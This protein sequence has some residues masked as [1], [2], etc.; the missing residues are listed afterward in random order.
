MKNDVSTYPAGT[1]CINQ[2]G[3]GV[4]Y[5]LLDA[6]IESHDDMAIYCEWTSYRI[7]TLNSSAARF[8]GV[9]KNEA[10]G[11]GFFDLMPA[12]FAMGDYEE[13]ASLKADRKQ[14]VELLLNTSNDKAFNIKAA[15][16]NDGV[17]F[18]IKNVNKISESSEET[19]FKMLFENM[20]SG[21]VFLKGITDDKGNITN[22]QILDINS[23]FEIYFDKDKEQAIGKNIDD[24]IPDIDESVM[25]I[26]AK[27]ALTGNSYSGKYYH[28][29]TKK[30]FEVRTYSPRKGFS[31]AVFNDI[32]H[33]IEVRNDL[34]IKN[35]ISKAFALGHDAS[36]YKVVLDFVLKNTGS[37]GGFIGYVHQGR[38]VICLAH[39][40]KGYLP[41]PDA[42]GDLILEIKNN[43]LEV[44]FDSKEQLLETNTFDCNEILTTPVMDKDKV[45]G[46]ISCTDP[47]TT[48]TPKA[49]N[50][51]Q[52]LADYIS[53]LMVA[54]I[55]ERQYKCQLVE[56]KERA[57]QNE[58]LKTAFLANMSHEVRTPMNSIIGFG[59]LLAK[60]TSLSNKDR[61]YVDYISQ[62]SKRL[63]YIIENIMEM[64]KLQTQQSK[65]TISSVNVNSMLKT[66]YNEMETF[67]HAK[68]ID[69][70][71][72]PSVSDDDSNIVTDSYK[73]KKTLTCLISNGI[74]FTS[75]G[76]VSYG[77]HIEDNYITF[78]VRD[79]G[80]GIRKELHESIFTSFQQAEN[81]L[82]R[83]YDGVGV[84]LSLCKGYIDILGGSIWLESAPNEG[85]TFY[86]R[87]KNLDT[88]LSQ[89]LN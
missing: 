10:L 30:H 46:I 41:P 8:L 20:S 82:E 70:I 19:N 50:F 12:Q 36:L 79:T 57:E 53:P 29:A 21:F 18:I 32:K 28:P 42:N 63:L 52:G 60:S 39:N 43:G 58:K 5:L 78:F 45:I 87:L 33:E 89:L 88:K 27:S 22:H 74:K 64:S 68:H 9:T 13:I 2:A 56:E 81:V 51:V 59:Q 1:F 47:Q 55:K 14:M 16:M 84:G 3:D 76:S 69:L 66:I 31:A 24:V 25:R 54:E 49:K 7:R 34:M 35:E 61:L 77:Y 62:A 6:L 65:A 44:V 26:L 48:F 73:V 38:E 75:K 72:Q 80:I 4:G 40:D 15:A 67:A 71:P 37:R 11:K 85:S 83:K 17:L 86:F 23:A